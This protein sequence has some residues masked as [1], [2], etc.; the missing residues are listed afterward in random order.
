MAKRS[1]E[2]SI[3]IDAPPEDVWTVFSNTARWQEWNPFV[4]SLE[5][6]MKQ[7]EKIKVRLEPPG[8]RPMTFKPKVTVLEP[9]SRFAWL[10]HLGIPGIFDG[11][12]RFALEPLPDG[13]TRFHQGEA[14][15]GLLVSPLLNRMESQVTQGFESMN[16]ALKT[17]VESR[18]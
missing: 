8:G 6:E 3:D 18:S 16:R 15:R 7:G 9:G 1:I 17:R 2:T 10:G 12:H 14:F 11:E 13:K 4:T 5:G